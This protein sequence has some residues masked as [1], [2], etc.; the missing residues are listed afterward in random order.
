MAGLRGPVRNEPPPQLKGVGVVPGRREDGEVRAATG[1]S[2]VPPGV[3][4]PPP[5]KDCSNGL[6]SRLRE[7]PTCVVKKS[8]VLVPC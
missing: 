3:S 7:P 5:P 6:G 8:G 1:G 2:L 4:G